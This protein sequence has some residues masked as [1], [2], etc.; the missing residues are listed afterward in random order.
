MKQKRHVFQLHSHYLILFNIHFCAV[1]NLFVAKTAIVLYR[2]RHLENKYA[3][4]KVQDKVCLILVNNHFWHLTN[5]SQCNFNGKS[6]KFTKKYRF[7][8][9][10]ANSCYRSTSAKRLNQFLFASV[11]NLLENVLIFD[12]F[13]KQWAGLCFAYKRSSNNNIE[14][15]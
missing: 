11:S 8:Y 5:W 4:V 10:N 15:L 14:R 2:C 9:V 12:C 1:C 3:I 13:P 6:Q 7:N